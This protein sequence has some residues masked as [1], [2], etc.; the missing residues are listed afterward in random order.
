[1]IRRLHGDE[2]GQ[3]LPLVA[4]FMVVLL[5][6]LA[7]AIDAGY[8]YAQRRYMQ[9]AA[10]AG[11]LAAC[12]VMAAGETRDSVVRST[13]V[14]YAQQNRASSVSMTYLDADKNPLPNPT[15]G[16]V[17]SNAKYIRVFTGI[18]FNTFFARVLG[19]NTM[20]ATA[21][22]AA[23]AF[24]GPTPWSVGSLAP[25]GV[26]E[27]FFDACSPPGAVCDLWD[28]TYFKAWGVPAAQFKTLIDLSNGAG[29]GSGPTNISDWTY[30]GYPGMISIDDWLPAVGGNYGNNVA[31]A[32]EQRIIDNPGGWDYDGVMWGYVD[33]IIWRN[34]QLADKDLGTPMR[35]QVLNFGRFKVRLSDIHGSQAWGHFIDYIV[36]GFQHGGDDDDAGPKVVLLTE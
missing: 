11:A 20:T 25:L 10:D 13:A 15:N 27:N 23:H 32:L 24:A 34:F 9:N 7:L 12:S 1:M 31:G 19:I 8:A 28:S 22:A 6:L 36:P 2:R 26:P 30:R 29:L 16:V 18:T 14:Y 33:I 17:P 3:I 21:S 35:V 4:L 5:G